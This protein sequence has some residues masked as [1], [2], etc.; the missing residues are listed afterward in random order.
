MNYKE[1]FGLKRS[2]KY[3]KVYDIDGT[4]LGYAGEV[5][6]KKDA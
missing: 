3:D 4:F 1:R 6:P 5:L 2:L